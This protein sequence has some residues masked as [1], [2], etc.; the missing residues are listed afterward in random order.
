MLKKAIC[1]IK[2][3]SFKFPD[4]FVEEVMNDIPNPTPGGG[5]G[6][7]GNHQA[8]P[9]PPEPPPKPVTIKVINKKCNC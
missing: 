8:P 2:K 7:G 3:C 4:N 9:P 1:V 6:D 5:T